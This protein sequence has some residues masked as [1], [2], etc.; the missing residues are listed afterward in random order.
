MNYPTTFQNS[1]LNRQKVKTRRE[2]CKFV[3]C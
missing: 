1:F 2:I 3:V